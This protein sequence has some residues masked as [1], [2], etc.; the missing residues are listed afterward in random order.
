MDGWTKIMALHQDIYSPFFVHF[1]FIT[2]VWICSFF[3]LNLTIASMLMKYASVDK[4]QEESGMSEP[5]RFE[6]EL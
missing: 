3:I 4:E 1:Y 5:D 2:V 6:L